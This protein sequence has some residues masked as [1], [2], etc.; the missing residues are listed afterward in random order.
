MKS[1]I[2]RL[3]AGC[4]AFVFLMGTV[5]I[6][7]YNPPVIAAGDIRLFSEHNYN[8]NGVSFGDKNP[9]VTATTTNTYYR[10]G[11]FGGRASRRPHRN[12][13]G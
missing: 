5:P 3:L 1:K 11:L 2:K 4:S 8:E 12:N 13:K 9:V 6:T 7:K 10:R